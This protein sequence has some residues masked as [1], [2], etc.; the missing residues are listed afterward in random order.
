MTKEEIKALRKQ[1]GLS[2]EEMARKIGVAFTTFHRWEK[3]GIKPSRLAL[4]KMIS[5]KPPENRCW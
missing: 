5:M 4:E 3:K 2:Q 1:L